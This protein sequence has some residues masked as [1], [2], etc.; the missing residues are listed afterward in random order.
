ME[1]RDD[2]N[3]SPSHLYN[4]SFMIQYMKKFPE[5]ANIKYNNKGQDM[6]LQMQMTHKAKL[7]SGFKYTHT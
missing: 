5:K 2:N 4:H 6:Y 1:E 3:T 7:S